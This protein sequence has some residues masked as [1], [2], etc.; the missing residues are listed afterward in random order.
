MKFQSQYNIFQTVNDLGNGLFHIRTQPREY[1]I[2]FYNFQSIKCI[3]KCS[4]QVFTILPHYASAVT[5]LR[6]HT[7]FFNKQ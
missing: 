1:R 6:T 4:L 7:L 5:S 3:W 2:K